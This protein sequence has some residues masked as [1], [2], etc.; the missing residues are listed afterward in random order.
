MTARRQTVYGRE[1]LSIVVAVNNMD[2]LEKNLLRSLQLAQGAQHEL[3]VKRDYP[4]AGLAYNSAIEESSNDL[5][6]FVHQDIFLPEDWFLE[7]ERALSYLEGNRIKWGVLG[8]YGCSKY[9]PQGKGTVYTTGLGVHGTPI[10]NPEPV[11]ALDEIVLIIR[12]SSELRFDSRMPHFHLYGTDICLSA[13]E[14]G[15]G[16][17]AF[18]A[19]CIH[20]TNQILRLPH[21]Y[22][23]CYDYIK[24]KW[25]TYLPIYTPCAV[26]QRFNKERYRELVSGVYRRV[27]GRPLLPAPRVEDPRTLI[28]GQ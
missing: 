7:L 10:V 19:F 26:V 15:L 28:S 1:K 2:V 3:I 25:R 16:C 18:Q 14:R 21:E 12:R 8:C 9:A 24:K 4:S 11:E 20:N 17:H 13:R 23:T 22:W 5:M 6:M 27:I